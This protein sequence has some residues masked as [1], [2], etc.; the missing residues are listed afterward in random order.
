MYF[1]S[2]ATATGYHLPSLPVL[3]KGV[4]EL[5]KMKMKMSLE[6]PRKQGKREEVDV[7]RSPAPIFSTTHPEAFLDNIELW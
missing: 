4:C 6:G 7:V 5:K 1:L 2:P 3:K